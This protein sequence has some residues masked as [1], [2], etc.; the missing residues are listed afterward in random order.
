MYNESNTEPFIVF[1]IA[2]YLFALPMGDVLQVVPC[3]PQSSDELKQ[4]GLIQLGAY[5]IKLVDLHRQC[6]A[7][8]VSPLP[9]SQSSLVLTRDPQ[10]GFCGILVYEPPDI[11]EFP[12]KK[13]RSLPQSESPFSVLKI[14]SHAAVLSWNEVTTTIFLLNVQRALTVTPTGY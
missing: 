13:M 12:S 6:N 10:G 14:A 7:E 11:I 5:T 4:V 1:R 9:E 3:P 8:D 2:T